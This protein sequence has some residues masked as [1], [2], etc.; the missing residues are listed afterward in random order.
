LYTPTQSINLKDQ[1]FPQIRLGLQGPTASGK[2]WAALTFPNPVVLDFDGSLTAHSGQNITSIPFYDANFCVDKLK[3]QIEDRVKYDTDQKVK[4]INK[5]DA[6]DKWLLTEGIKLAPEQTLII[7]SWTA[8]QHAF[9]MM[10]ETEPYYTKKGEIDDY[11]FWQIKVEW[12]RSLLENLKTLR[13]HSVVTFHETQ[14]RDKITGVLLDKIQP[15]MQGKFIAQIKTPFTDFFRQIMLEWDD[16][17]A[18]EREARG[19]KRE[20]FNAQGLG[21]FWQIKS[22]NDFDAK[23]RMSGRVETLVPAHFNS[24]NYAPKA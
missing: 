20:H 7:D 22:G 10:T 16:K 5:R 11:A 1:D 14:S 21:W 8:V 15:L 3:L 24:F 2:S 17:L 19:I 9:D 18:K 6:L 13:C 12:S 4:V 23:C